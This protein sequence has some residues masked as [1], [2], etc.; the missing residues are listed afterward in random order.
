MLLYFELG[1]SPGRELSVDPLLV[2]E[3]CSWRLPVW[4]LPDPLKVEAG[5]RLRVAYSYGS[6]GQQDRMSISRVPLGE[7]P[8][9]Q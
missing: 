2:D 7:T 6:T 4:L 1:L 9:P 8:A 3:Q 5:E